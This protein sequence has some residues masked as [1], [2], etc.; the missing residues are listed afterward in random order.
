MCWDG[1]YVLGEF[2]L[3]PSPYRFGRFVGAT[4]EKGGTQKG[5]QKGNLVRLIEGRNEVRQIV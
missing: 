4:V 1:G 3:F 5:N 2:T